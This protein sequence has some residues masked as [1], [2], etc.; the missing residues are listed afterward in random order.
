M[1]WGLPG[2]LRRSCFAWCG[3]GVHC[4]LCALRILLW[5]WSRFADRLQLAG[6]TCGRTSRAEHLLAPLFVSSLLAQ[7]SEVI[8][9]AVV[10][11]PRYH[12]G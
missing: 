6:S 1:W 3:V 11:V 5:L 10:Q 4:S 2:F 8:L 9:P 7:V 12:L